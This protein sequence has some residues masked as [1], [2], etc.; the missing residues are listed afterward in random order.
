[1][2]IESE[3]QELREQVRQL[4][5][6]LDRLNAIEAV[7]RVKYKYW[8]C[9]DTAD[10]GGM[11]E[12]LHEDVF[13][14]IEA[15]IYSMAYEGR[16]AYLEMVKQGAHCDMI[17]HHNGHHGEIDIVSDDEAIG[18]WYLYDDLYE[19]RRGM[20]LFGTAFYRD[21]YV[22]V[23]GE[24]KIRY[25]QFHRIYEIKQ[26]LGERPEITYHY[27]ATHGY[28]HE[29]EVDLAPYPKDT[30]YRHPPGEMPP[31]LDTK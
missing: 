12:V 23:E 28:K 16:D 25:S 14:S 24:W 13:L 17:S 21:R 19:F 11:A 9:F 2:S 18:T 10:L 29:G 22:R 7:K 6:Q 5:V 1:M 26:A 3:I 15:G 27:L 4:R 30:G 31:F 20:R 8:R